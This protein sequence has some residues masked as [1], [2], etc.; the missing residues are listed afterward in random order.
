MN[1]YQGCNMLVMEKKREERERELKVKR[2]DVRR[3]LKLSK[4]DGDCYGQCT[5]NDEDE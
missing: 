4:V 1:K 2:V 3:E 5:C